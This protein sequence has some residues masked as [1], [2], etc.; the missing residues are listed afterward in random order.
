[1]S[2]RWYYADGD[3]PVGPFSMK[4]LADA[5][6]RSPNWK[7]VLVWREGDG[8]WRRAGNFSEL[9]YLNATPPPIPQ[10]D[11]F[12]R[13]IANEPRPRDSSG[14][15][16]PA[17]KTVLLIVGLFFLAALI[18]A[19]FLE[20]RKPFATWSNLA[21]AHAVGAALGLWLLSGLLPIAVWAF[22]RF[23]ANNAGGPLYA[24]FVLLVGLGGLYAF[25]QHYELEQKIEQYGRTALTDKHRQ[26]FIVGA[27]NGCIKTQRQDPLTRQAGITD[28]Q[29]SSYCECYANALADQLTPDEVVYYAKFG[30][31]SA[32]TQ[33][34]I[35]DLLP[36]CIRTA[37]G[38]QSAAPEQ[39]F[40]A[41]QGTAHAETRNV[42]HFVAVKL[43]RGIE[44]HLPRGW[45]LIGP[46]LNRLIEM[47]SEA[48]LD[49]SGI[50]MAEGQRTNLIAANSMPTSTYAAVRVDSTIPPSASPSELATATTAEIAELERETRANLLKNLPMQGNQLID[51][52]GV[53]IDKISDRLS[54][55]TEYRRSGPKGPVIVQLN[56]IFTD[57]QEIAINLSYR[58]SETAIWKP[59]I[60]RIRQSIVVTRW[61]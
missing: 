40:Q 3:R 17:R 41:T 53:R 61:P 52:Y 48:A 56:Q 2:D 44:L 14:S 5:L 49:L 7:E 34:K 43:P 55:V 39:L 32:T 28:A 23:R 42:S 9:D 1:M 50:G 58:E 20:M 51:F 33:R 30:K 12:D 16:G 36:T 35:E 21:Y 13:R 10:P 37:V 8:D 29:I 45:Y 60:A 22:R 38:K 19:I 59:V 24:W 46:D 15:T 18:L 11:S 25:G 54:V 6:N 27:R 47:S 57:K 4:E 31:P 26:G